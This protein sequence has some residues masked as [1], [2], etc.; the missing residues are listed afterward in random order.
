M[1]KL[2]EKYQN[3]LKYLNELIE[4]KETAQIV[5]RTAIKRLDAERRGYHTIIDDIKK[6]LK[7]K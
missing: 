7:I 4:I 2:L 3:K 6:E 5:D 1:E